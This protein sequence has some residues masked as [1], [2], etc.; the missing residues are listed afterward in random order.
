MDPG[1][2]E[3]LVQIPAVGMIVIDCVYVLSILGC[4]DQLSA[5]STV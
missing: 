5:Y 4:E 2:L 3:W 1:V